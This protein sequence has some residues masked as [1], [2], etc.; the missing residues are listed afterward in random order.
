MPLRPV[1]GTCDYVQISLFLVRP[2]PH[3]SFTG[4]LQQ[5]RCY[6]NQNWSAIFFHLASN[7]RTCWSRYKLVLPLPAMSQLMVWPM[8]ASYGRFFRIEREIT[9]RKSSDRLSVCLIWER[10]C[11]KTIFCLLTAWCRV[12]LEKLTGLQLVKKYIYILGGLNY[13]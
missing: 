3:P 9:G 2:Q 5:Y 8:F 10:N 11:M 13:A 12:L 4:M 7:H 1:A 6:A